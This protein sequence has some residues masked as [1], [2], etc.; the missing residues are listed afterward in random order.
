MAIPK[1]FPLA[2]PPGVFRSGTLYQ[3]KGR[4][5][6]SHLC[7][8][9]DS[10]ALGPIGGWRTKTTSTM[11]GTPR[12]II[13][14][15]DNTGVRRT[16]IGT[17]SKLYHMTSTGVLTD[18]TNAAFVAGRTDATSG[19]GYG[20]GLYGANTYGTP[21]PDGA[22]NPLTATMWDLDVWGQYLVGCS[23][24][25]GVLWEWQNDT[26]TDAAAIANAPTSCYGLVVHP[27]GILIA[28]GAGGNPRKFQWCDIRANTVW[29]PAATNQAGSNEIQQGKLICGRAVG[30]QVIALTDIDA[31]VLEYRGLPFVIVARKVGDACGA[32][33]KG[34]M[35]T[36]GSFA[37]WW[38]KSGFWMYDGAVRPIQCDVWDDLQRNMSVAQQSKVTGFHNAK[39][40]EIWWFYPRNGIENSH[41]VYWSY[42]NPNAL[43]W[44][45]GELSRLAACAPGIFENPFAVASDGNVYEHE[46]GGQYSGDTP[47]AQSGPLQI[48]NGDRR[49]HVLGIVPDE[50]TSGQVSVS[51]LAREYPNADEETLGEATLDNTGKADVRFSARQAQLVVTGATSASWRWGE[52]RLKVVAGGRR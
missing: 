21:R 35:V 52:P 50:N 49:A 30:Q 25:D 15:R 22:S 36:T 32:I 19:T 8:W 33:S 16:A 12:A 51:F 1:L 23:H 2:I 4:W 31:H 41:Y 11:T 9:Y 34:C 18:I 6:D 14:W 7:R 27:V 5:Y 38:S 10:V 47:E 20:T 40:Q 42:K 48:G 44:G 3:S 46:Y 39:N 45:N 26:G 43:H 24:D 13:T 17:H 29:T 28:L 37:V